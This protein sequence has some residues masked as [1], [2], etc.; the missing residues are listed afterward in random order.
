MVDTKRER[1]YIFK[2]TN[3]EQTK[4]N[5]ETNNNNN[6]KTNTKKTTTKKKNTHTHKLIYLHSYMV[7]TKLERN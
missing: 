4:T 7:D 1:D 6:N 3:N 2:L 5:K